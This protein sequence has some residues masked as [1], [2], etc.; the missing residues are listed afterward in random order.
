MEAE[1]IAGTQQEAAQPRRYLKPRN[2]AAYL[3]LSD[4]T[5]EEWRT[6]GGGPPFVKLSGKIVLYDIHDLDAWVASLKVANTS[7]PPRSR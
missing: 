3:D 5:L 4:R 7:V 1:R 6:K 2:A